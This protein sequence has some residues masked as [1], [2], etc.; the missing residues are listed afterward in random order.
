MIADTKKKRVLRFAA[1]LL[2][3]AMLLTSCASAG[4][5]TTVSQLQ[6]GQK[7]LSE[8]NY[9]EAIA[10]FTEAIPRDFSMSRTMAPLCPVSPKSRPS[11]HPE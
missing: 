5:S 11:R 7:Y 6:L 9:S 2:F 8:M 4:R 1:F 3:A 10:A